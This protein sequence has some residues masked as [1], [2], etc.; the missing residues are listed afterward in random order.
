MMTAHEH[1]QILRLDAGGRPLEWWTWQKAVAAYCRDE[2]LWEAGTDNFEILGGR[3]RFT[4]LQSRLSVNSIIATFGASQGSF[5]LAPPLN[6]R[7]LFRRD[8]HL[9]M[10]CGERFPVSQL[11]RDHVVPVSRGGADCWENVISACKACNARK[12]DRTPEEAGMRLLAVPYRP[13]F[14]EHL[15]LSGRHIR[16]DQ[17][18]YLRQLAP[19]RERLA[20]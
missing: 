2:V 11:S 16:A 18:A 9:C 17:M 19:R 3:N 5:D 12:A 20:A 6:N 8:D 4:G 1:I 14:A 15:L 10:Y 13:T 7:E